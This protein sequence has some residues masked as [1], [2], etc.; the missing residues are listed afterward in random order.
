MDCMQWLIVTSPRKNPWT[1]ARMVGEIMAVWFGSVHQLAMVGLRIR[2][3]VLIQLADGMVLRRQ[4]MQSNTYAVIQSILSRYRKKFKG[5]F[6]QIMHR[7]MWIN[8]RFLIASLKSRYAAI[9]RTQVS[10]FYLYNTEEAYTICMYTSSTTRQL[11][12]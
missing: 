6:T 7:E 2:L 3:D 4:L 10:E 1:P 12:L 9:T 8:C 11:T 5:C